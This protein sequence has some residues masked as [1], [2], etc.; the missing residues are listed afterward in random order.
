[1]SNVK[2]GDRTEPVVTRKLRHNE[3][4]EEQA[5]GSVLS[6]IRKDPTTF[7]C[8]KTGETLTRP[9]SDARTSRVDMKDDRA[10][11]A[12]P[13]TLNF[14]GPCEERATVIEQEEALAEV[15]A[16]ARKKFEAERDAK[17]PVNPIRARDDAKKA[18]TKK[19]AGKKGEE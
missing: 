10:G 7:F 11:G 16:E 3:T 1:M 19:K 9:S 13:W 18:A 14:M 6:V 4:I 8:E 12:E 15:E 2:R 5:D 17:R